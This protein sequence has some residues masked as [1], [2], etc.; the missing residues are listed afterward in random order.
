MRRILA[1]RTAIARPARC[2]S[3]MTL[4]ELMVS[5]GATSVLLAGMSSAVLLASLAARP[6]SPASGT[7]EASVTARQ[8]TAELSS[9]MSIIDLTPTSIEFTVADRDA[10]GMAETIRYAW[11]GTTGSSL[12]RQYNGDT[13]VD[14]LDNVY[15]F[16]L[17]YHTESN[18]VE[19]DDLVEEESAEQLLAQYDIAGNV[20]T[21][22]VKASFWPGQ[23][24]SPLLSTDVVHWRVTRVEAVLEKETADQMLHVQLRS[25]TS[26]T[27]PS[28]TI[29]EEVIVNSDSLAD[30][31]DW[32]TFE[33]NN[34]SHLH[35][36]QKLLLVF[37]DDGAGFPAKVKCVD[38]PGPVPRI[39]LVTS[40]NQGANWLL[41][42][43]TNC[44]FRV[45]GTVTTMIDAAESTKGYLN[46][47]ALE[48][49]VGSNTNSTVHTA[50]HLHNRPEVTMP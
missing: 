24:F 26:A 6:D 3:G 28:A 4:L 40:T 22:D 10:N 18:D 41:I 25:A 31:F 2:P 12:T 1:N 16:G 36:T 46:R 33:F 34:V 17:T 15:D 30:V 29:L 27:T 21:Y 5:M 39:K 37:T 9:A 35:P 47:I 13:E 14:V 20:Q 42:P 50:V 44:Q 19:V 38:T 23:F 48:I 43:S 49:L 32:R 11:D 7:I 8:I 45:W